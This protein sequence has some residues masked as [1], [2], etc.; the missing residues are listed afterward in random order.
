MPKTVMIVDDALSI[1]GL[2][3]MTLENAGYAVIEAH[4]GKDALNRLAGA[5]PDLIIVD[6]YM[7]EMDG[8][9][10][11]RTLKSDARLKFIPIVVL[12]K[13]ADPQMKEQGRQAGVRAW[14]VKPFKPDT[15]LSVTRKII[16]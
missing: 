10:L 2:I 16:G 14:I 15:I 6:I 8:M 7:P 3:R 12:S 5:A 11:I 13:E 9:A 1:R 4:N